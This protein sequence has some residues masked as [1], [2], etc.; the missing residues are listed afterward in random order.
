M[1]PPHRR[2][3]HPGAVIIPIELL[4]GNYIVLY[5]FAVVQE[6]VFGAATRVGFSKNVFYGVKID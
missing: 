3:V 4:A 5:L 2:V 1:P 6:L